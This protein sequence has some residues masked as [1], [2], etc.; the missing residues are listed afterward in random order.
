MHYDMVRGKDE[1]VHLIRQRMEQEEISFKGC[2]EK[3]KE[4]RKR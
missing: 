3:Q 4:G 1:A 2:L